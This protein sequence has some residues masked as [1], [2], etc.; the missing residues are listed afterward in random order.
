MSPRQNRTNICLFGTIPQFG[1]LEYSD[2]SE[3]SCFIEDSSISDFNPSME[4]NLIVDG[5][6]TGFVNQ[7]QSTPDTDV[8]ANFDMTAV[9]HE[10][11]TSD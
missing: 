8:P 7:W 2:S 11:S 10:A 3:F 4:T 5:S 6:L 9:D 1:S